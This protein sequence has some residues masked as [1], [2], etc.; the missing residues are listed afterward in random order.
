M[1]SQRPGERASDGPSGNDGRAAET[2]P[3]DKGTAATKTTE[4]NAAETDAMLAMAYADGELDSAARAAFEARWTKEPALA[5][6]VANERRL[7]VVAREFA[8]PEPLELEWQRLE[9]SALQRAGRRASWSVLVLGLGALTGSAGAFVW[10]SG[11]PL[12][13]RIG[14]SALVLGLLGLL[15]LTLH[16]RLR[17]RHLDPYVNVK[18]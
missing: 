5:L 9:R 14:V 12:A 2:G 3:S 11:L 1:S 8:P 15:A 16:N 6:L 13:A 17:T 10:T 4:A 18:R 7:A